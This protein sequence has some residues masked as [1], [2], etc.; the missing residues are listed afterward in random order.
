MLSGRF[1]DAR[2]SP[3]PP[4]THIQ[5]HAKTQA[6]SLPVIMVHGVEQVDGLRVQRQGGLLQHAQGKELLPQGP[7]A[8]D[9]LG[10]IGAVVQRR[11]VMRNAARQSGEGR[12]ARGRGIMHGEGSMLP[13]LLPIQA[14]DAVN[15]RH[16]MLPPRPGPVGPL[17]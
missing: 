1:V 17:A 13:P 8:N 16:P 2:T 5:A 12:W 7:A 9:K 14:V 6:Q 11:D 4:S 3:P 10:S 15:A